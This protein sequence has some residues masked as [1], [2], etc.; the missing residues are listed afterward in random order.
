MT[1][2]DRRIQ[3]SI[4]NDTVNYY[5]ADIAS[6]NDYYPFGMVMPGRTFTASS[7]YRYGFS[8]KEK[9]K[10]VSSLT[11]YDYGF[12][13]Y[14]PAIGRF[15]SVDPLAKKY[16]MLSPYQFA[17]NNPIRYIDLDGLEP[18]NNPKSPGKKEK[19]AMIAVDLI[20]AGAAKHDAEENLLSSGPYRQSNADLKGT[21]ACG[22]NGTYVTDS[23]G[24]PKNK[25]NMKVFTGAT[26][27][28]DESQAKHFD[29]YE[30]F[31]VDRLMANFTTG[32]G[33]ENYNF[34]TNGI[35]S[36]KF[37]TSDILRSAL[38][39]FNSG[40]KVESEQ[41]NFGAKELAKDFLRTGTLFSITGLTGSGTITMVPNKD[42]VQ[43]RIFNV[44]SLTSGDLVKNPSS[45]ANWPKSYV[46]DQ[47]KT[48]PYGNIS[49]TYNLFLPWNSP[50]LKRK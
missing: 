30:A 9:D 28:V 49:Q 20:A 48:T 46:R 43:I 31:V 22:P 25:F 32:K 18:E 15:L 10:N 2:T 4:N 6:A 23:K 13:I 14:N 7:D 27:N 17:G 1:I 44:T 45:D 47:Q 19:V 37:L 24:D 8:G 11:A 5:K 29:N 33:A 35:I 36:S 12:R 50:L 39:K 16:P 3:A 34:P 38:E 42:G 26:L 40:N 21:Y 41:F